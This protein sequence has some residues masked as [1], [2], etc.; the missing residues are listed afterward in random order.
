MVLR[1]ACVT[2]ELL[3]RLLRNAE[4]ALNRVGG[5]RALGCRW[6]ALTEACRR[7]R[8]RRPA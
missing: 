3:V 2:P 5:A 1:D 8:D 7:G 4:I 6:A